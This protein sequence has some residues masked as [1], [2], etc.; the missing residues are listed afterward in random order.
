MQETE[1]VG[2]GCI[3]RVGGEDNKEND[4]IAVVYGDVSGDGNV[5]SPDL[6]KVRDAMLSGHNTLTGA[7]LEAATPK[8]HSQGQA[9]AGSDLIAI[10]D[11]VLTNGNTDLG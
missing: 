10:R 4:V 3:I 1:K 7:Y 6:L 8:T 5:G 2:T 9:P 11:Y